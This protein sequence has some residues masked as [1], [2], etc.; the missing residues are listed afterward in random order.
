MT[1]YGIICTRRWAHRRD[2]R[3]RK[4]VVVHSAAQRWSVPD[5]TMRAIFDDISL[6]VV[7]FLEAHQG[8][9]DVRFAESPPATSGTCLRHVGTWEN[10][11]C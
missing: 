10:D 4:A 2:V 8:V 3:N 7:T 11:A 9:T 6:S 5:G 1:L